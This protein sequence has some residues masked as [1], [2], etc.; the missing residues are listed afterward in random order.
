MTHNL[1][2][3]KLFYVA[4]FFSFYFCISK[5]RIS[6]EI[7]YVKN[8]LLYPWVQ[9]VKY[10][11][12]KYGNLFATQL[13]IKKNITLCEEIKFVDYIKECIVKLFIITKHLRNDH[14]Y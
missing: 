1:I 11:F 13:E 7:R 4:Y 9:Y 6:I 2:L 12:A 3:S 5:E 8:F 14:C 10:A